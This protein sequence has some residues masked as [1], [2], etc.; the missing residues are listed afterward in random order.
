MHVYAHMH[1]CTD[2]CTSHESCL[3]LKNNFQEFVL[4]F[5]PVDPK[6]QAQVTR[7]WQL[8]SLFAEPSCQF[9]LPH[10]LFSWSLGTQTGL[11]FTM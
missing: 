1:M 4:S 3:G 9:P 5:Y 6:N 11:K 8:V 10:S 2:T 7:L